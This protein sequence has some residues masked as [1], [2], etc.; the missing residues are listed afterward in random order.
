MP[1]G[2]RV[3]FSAGE[4]RATAW[5]GGIEGMF[6]A[7]N[8]GKELH[9]GGFSE[10]RENLLCGCSFSPQPGLSALSDRNSAGKDGRKGVLRFLQAHPRLLKERKLLQRRKPW[11][12]L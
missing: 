7:Y 9:R 10:K 12:F 5:V 8:S 3:R 6:F 1:D 11:W 4:D 2:V